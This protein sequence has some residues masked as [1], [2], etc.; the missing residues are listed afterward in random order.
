MDKTSLDNQGRKNMDETILSNVNVWRSEMNDPESTSPKRKNDKIT[1]KSNLFELKPQ[2][3]KKKS[4][5]S[6]FITLQSEGKGTN[7]K[8]IFNINVVF[9]SHWDDGFMEQIF[10]LELE[11]SIYHRI[12]REQH[13]L[14][15]YSKNILISKMTDEVLIIIANTETFREDI[16]KKIDQIAVKELQIQKDILDGISEESDLANAA[17]NILRLYSRY[18]VFCR[19]HAK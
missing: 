18:G 1:Q 14:S 3:I 4:K 8:S 2:K 11:G 12:E 10:P 6:E 16:L 9:K 17:T 7:M 15:I 13:V 5:V 19:N